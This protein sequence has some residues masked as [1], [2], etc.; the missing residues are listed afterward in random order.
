MT[1]RPERRSGRPSIST[2]LSGDHDDIDE[3]LAEVLLATHRRAW[4]QAAADLQDL[5]EHLRRH[6]AIEED[7]LFPLFDRRLKTVGPTRILRLEHRR[8]TR[9]FE[10]MLDAIRAHS[11]DG[12]SAAIRGVDEVLPHHMAKEESILYPA[13]DRVLSDD[14]QETVVERIGHQLHTS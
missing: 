4:E 10:A 1:P 14:E 8:L 3:A 11:L 13:I 9:S 12:V 6:V 7:I 2:A 5:L